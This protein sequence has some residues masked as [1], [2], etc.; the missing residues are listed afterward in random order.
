MRGWLALNL[1]NSGAVS[2]L[3]VS[4]DAHSMLVYA[5]DGSY[6]EMQE[7]KVS[8]PLKSIRYI[9]QPGLTTRLLRSWK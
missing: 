7:V 6:V 2:K 5:A 9:P 3:H 8:I 1:V 4:L